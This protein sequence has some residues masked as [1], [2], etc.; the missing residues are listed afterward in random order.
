[1][2]VAGRAGRA[3]LSAD[4]SSGEVL[5]QT[6]YPHHPLYQAVMRHDYDGFA[7]DLLEERRQAHSRPS[8]TRR[9]CGPRRASW[10]RP[11]AS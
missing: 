10:T 5:I 2:Q 9:C 6:R 3:G 11:W 8:C 4:G 7:G 1:M